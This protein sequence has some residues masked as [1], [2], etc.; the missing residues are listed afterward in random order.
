MY[1]FLDSRDFS[2]ADF[3]SNSVWDFIVPFNEGLSAKTCSLV[4]IGVTSG[5]NGTAKFYR[6]QPLYVFC[7]IV[8][9][10]YVRERF[11]PL[12]KIVYKPGP[13]VKPYTMPVT[14]ENITRIRLYIL[15]SQLKT[16]SFEPESLHCTL[17]LK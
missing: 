7:D 11:L 13:V 5:K 14:H 4:D 1:L 12:L 3:P 9:P 17:L 10:S 16:P 2:R 6:N 8:E 15:D